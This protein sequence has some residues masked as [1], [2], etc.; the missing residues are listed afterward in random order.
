MNTK[1]ATTTIVY[2]DDSVR[3]FM[4]ASIF[5]GIVGMGA[6]VLIAFQL[7]FWQMNGKF[8]EWLTLG[9]LKSE[10]I[11]FLTFGRLRPLHTNAAIFAFVGNMMFAG[12][13][14]ST[15]RLCR[16][17][18]ASDLLSKI[19]FWG[20]QFIIVCAAISLPAGFTRGKEYAELIWP[21]N[22]MVAVIWLIFAA[23]FFWTLAKRNEKSLYVGLWFY[24]ATIVTI[25][26]LYVVNHLS[27][28]T[29]F[30]HSYPIFGGVQ[31]ALVQWWYGHNAVAFFLT[32][33]MLG[34][35]YYF[36]PKAAN[37]PVYSYRLSIIHFWSL[38]F[39]YIWAGPHHLLNTALPEWLQ[40]LGM[41]FSLMLWAPSWAGMLNGLLTLRGAW[42]KLLTDPIIKFF[43]AAVTFYGMCTFEGPLLSI[44]AVNALSHYTDWTVGHVHSGTLGWNGF[45]AAGMFY[46][47]APRLWKT[48]L[49]S[50]ALANAHFWMGMVGILLYVASMWVAGIT[51]GLMLN[52]TIEGGTLLQYPNFLDTLQAIRPVML[53]RAIGGFLYVTGFVL[54]AYNIWRTAKSGTAVNGTVEVEVT[55]IETPSAAKSFLSAPVIY[56]LLIVFAVCLTI[57]SNGALFIFGTFLTITFI[58]VAIAHFE[59]CKATWSQWYDQLLDHGFAFTVLT[60]IAAGIGGAIQIIPTVTMQR[61][62][63]IEGRIQVPYTPLELAGRDIYVS[64][65]CYN[66]HSQMIRTLVPD[67][68][69]YGDQGQGGGYSHLGESIY[70]YPYQWGSKRTGPDLAR[71]GGVRS[72]DWHFFHMLDPR[73]VSPGSNMPNY[74]WLFEKP[75]KVSQLPRKIDVMRMLGVPY[76]IDLSPEDIESQI[77][78]QAAGI[79]ER[80]AEKGAFT[81]P[82]REIVAL[83]AYL[84]KLGTYELASEKAAREAAA[85]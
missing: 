16:T 56:S 40:S 33:P 53:F 22:I 38:V 69:R 54:C 15:Q 42:D 57:F 27:I 77:N 66:C 51:Q 28:P 21:I 62:D 3:K 65:G 10:G 78:E 67:V 12:I 74:P 55:D 34:I 83:I 36:V 14:Y 4:I 8:I 47:L 32:T 43:A 19:N 26:M 20:W 46:W 70:D 75:I 41:V 5:W 52:A 2:D 68:M 17:R 30:T 9:A 31:D 7:N 18:M 72:D 25:T 73:S 39:I 29:S 82:D 59:V 71:E 45:L 50:T 1:P 48:K 6:G 61:A 13:Y 11:E 80:L 44:K 24:I 63:N 76:P 60:I 79:V 81:D 35:M 58:I 37:R 64:E 49:Y 84:Q 23:N 85:E